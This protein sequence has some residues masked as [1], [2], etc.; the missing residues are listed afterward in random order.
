MNWLTFA[1]IQGPSYHTPIRRFYV[2][3]EKPNKYTTRV[4]YELKEVSIKLDPCTF[5]QI[6]RVPN[7]GDAI[8]DTKP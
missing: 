3:L 8:P 5:C 1:R 7:E 2:G 4:Y 6:L